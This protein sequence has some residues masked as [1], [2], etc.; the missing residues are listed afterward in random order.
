MNKVS[1]TRSLLLGTAGAL[2][3]LAAS[4]PAEAQNFPPGTN[5]QSLLPDLR[6]S[7]MNQARQMNSGVSG[8]TVIPNSA[9]SNTVTTPG[10]NSLNSGT[11]VSPSGVAPSTVAPSTVSPTGTG[12]APTGVTTPNSVTPNTNINPNVVTPNSTTNP[13]AVGRPGTT[14]NPNAVGAP[15]GNPVIIPPAGTGATGTG[16]TGTGTMGTGTGSSGG[17]S[18]G[19]SG[20]GSSG[21]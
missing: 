10:T 20:S 21:N 16:T 7:C 19:A 4:A 14:I 15:T 17:S 12:V 3:G 1:L 13:N 5:C 11:G 18:G 9:G 2:L 8:N 6:A